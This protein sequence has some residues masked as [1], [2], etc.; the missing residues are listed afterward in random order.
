V[1]DAIEDLSD[2]VRMAQSLGGFTRAARARARAVDLM[3]LVG[4]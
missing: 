3:V 2:L 1:I 4:R